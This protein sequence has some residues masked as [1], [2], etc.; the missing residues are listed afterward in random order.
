MGRLSS[1]ENVDSGTSDGLLWRFLGIILS[2]TY[3]I[4]E[5]IH[6]LLKEN[7]ACALERGNNIIRPTI[8]VKVTSASLERNGWWQGLRLMHEILT[9]GRI[10]GKR[11]DHNILWW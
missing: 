7:N 4:V 11:I 1:G 2:K 8:K 3:S 9:G 10:I 6:S 5:P